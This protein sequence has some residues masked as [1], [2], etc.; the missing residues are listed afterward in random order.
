MS[1]R[2]NARIP[3]RDNLAFEDPREFGRW[4]NDQSESWSIIAAKLAGYLEDAGRHAAADQ[5]RYF[6]ELSDLALAV[7]K[8][9]RGAAQTKTIVERLGALREG[10][11]WDRE[12]ASFKKVADLAGRDPEAAAGFLLLK[13]GDATVDFTKS[14]APLA[15]LRAMIGAATEGFDSK[16]IEEQGRRLEGA[17]A[18]AESAFSALQ[19]RYREALRFEAPATYWRRKRRCHGAALGAAGL[20][21]VLLSGAVSYLVWLGWPEVQTFLLE[22][23]V[24][25]VGFS[26]FAILALPTLLLAW[27]LWLLARVFA[28]NLDYAMDAGQRTAMLMTYRAIMSGQEPSPVDRRVMLETVFGWRGPGI[29]SRK[30]LPTTAE[31][32]QGAK[33]A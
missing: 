28:R 5:A 31:A 25:G 16:R 21:F 12:S 11:R 9:G 33:G 14:R 13:S 15:V 27:P 22:L 8:E 32:G 4:A 29:D 6:K 20:G 26:L 23:V 19:G 24:N 18:S 7:K 17:L 2:K 30:G 3:V 1:M 10:N